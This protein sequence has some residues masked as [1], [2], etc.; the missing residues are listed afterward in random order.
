MQEGNDVL[1]LTPPAEEYQASFLQAVG[2]FQAE[3]RY[4]EYDA[5]TL[6]AD[7]GSFV[8]QL[9]DRVDRTR[10]PP[11]RVP[12]TVFWLIDGVEFIGR[13]SLRHE[14]NSWLSRYGGHIGYEI[15][16]TKRRQGYG[17][18]ALRLVL[19]E[20]RALGLTRALI[21]CDA[22]NIGSR[23]II[24]ANGGQFENAVALDGTPVKR[25]RYWID[26][27]PAAADAPA[28]G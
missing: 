3:N 25:L 24:E 14:L 20:A 28:R 18:A 6:A 27:T 8:R 13:V 21:T 26:L 9:R 16:P 17:T 11:G 4:T 12:E 19:P 23:R 1:L 10:L 5:A 2:E 22:D 7:F 15:R